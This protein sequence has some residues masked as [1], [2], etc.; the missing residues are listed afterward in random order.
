MELYNTGNRLFMI[1]EVSEDF[2]FARKAEMDSANP[3]VREWESL[4]QYQQAVPWGEPG[5]KWVLMDK[6]FE[7][8]P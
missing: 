6:L 8:S 2:S 7:I 5:E 3:A 1:I 4:S